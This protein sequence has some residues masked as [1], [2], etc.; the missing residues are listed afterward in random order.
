MFAFT[1]KAAT[2]Y[3][4]TEMDRKTGRGRESRAI[5][6]RSGGTLTAAVCANISDKEKWQVGKTTAG[7]MWRQKMIHST[8]LKLQMPFE[9]T[10]GIIDSATLTENE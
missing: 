3:L 7:K 8:L 9:S 4:G 10:R 5:R 1:L 2:T 6:Q